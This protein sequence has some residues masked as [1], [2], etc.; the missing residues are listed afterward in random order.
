[1]NLKLM[2]PTGIVLDEAVSK[3]SAEAQN[4]SFTL[5]PNHIDFVAS[6]VPGIFSF[7]PEGGSEE[8]FAV[9]EGV[10]I[11]QGKVVRVSVLDAVRGP[12]LAQLKRTVRERFTKREEQERKARAATARMEANFVRRFL[13]IKHD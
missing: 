10:L 4:G 2:T 8:Y 9:D 1:M 12:D 13:E 5:L 6:L 3:V 7:V 11:K